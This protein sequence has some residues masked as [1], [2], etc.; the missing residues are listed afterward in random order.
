MDKI[1][2]VINHK[3]GVGKTTSSVSIGSG[4]S[5]MDKKVLLIDLDPQANLTLHFSLS[6]IQEPNIYDALRGSCNLPIT[7]VKDNLDVVTSCLDLSAAESELSVIAGREY[8]LKELIEPIKD[9]YDFILIDCPPSL[10]LLTLNALAVS[11]SM[12]IPIDMSKFAI[13]G[14]NKLFEVI[15]LVQKRLNPN[16]N[17]FKI[18]LTK[19]DARKTLHNE[20]QEA[21]LKNYLN[22]V[23]DTLISTNVALEEAQMNGVDIFSY[24]PNSSG[25]K[26]YK[27]V[28]I[29]IMK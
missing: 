10:G 8:I 1:I 22:N 15:N 26:Q 12:I 11:Q 21:I 5:L 23:F 7:K 24:N 18:L 2:S 29:E 19:V 27:S 9:N 13:A 3:G 4:L 20:I 28:C 25:A 16:L 14:M 6:V 17:Q